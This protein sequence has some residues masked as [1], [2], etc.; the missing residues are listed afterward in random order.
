[1]A[2][3]SR[4]WS[5]KWVGPE[6]MNERSCHVGRT[7]ERT[8]GR[9]PL[10]SI[11]IPQYNRTSFLLVLLESLRA[12]TWRDFEICIS[13]GGSTDGRQ[14]EIEEWLHNCGAEFR[15]WRSETRLLYDPNLRS[16]IA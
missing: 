13:D 16:C 3:P 1:M 4:P 6:G 14:G 5:R 15:W 7:V 12:Q 9:V 2:G 10:F 11:C 8:T